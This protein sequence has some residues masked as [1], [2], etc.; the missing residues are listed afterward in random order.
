MIN[1]SCDLNKY[2]PYKH[3]WKLFQVGFL[4]QHIVIA[5]Y[6]L[7]RNEKLPEFFPYPFNDSAFYGPD[8]NL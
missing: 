4:H 8:L 2:V 1:L 5:L 7:D 3:V 6:R